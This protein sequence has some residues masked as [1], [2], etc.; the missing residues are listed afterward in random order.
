VKNNLENLEKD[1]KDYI[2]KIRKVLNK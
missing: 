1:L 2:R